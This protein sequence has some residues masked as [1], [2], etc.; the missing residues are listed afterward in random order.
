MEVAGQVPSLV[1]TSDKGKR[2]LQPYRPQRS[3]V[4]SVLDALKAVA[5][6]ASA[7]DPPCWL[8]DGNFPDPANVIAFANGLLDVEAYLAGSVDLLDHTPNWFSCNCLPHGFDQD[9]VCPRWLEFLDQ[10]FDGDASGSPASS[11]GWA[12]TSSPTIG[13]K[14]WRC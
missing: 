9:A 6:H 14:N 7:V 11:S 4:T 10:V 1:Q 12:T 2:V 8:E 3:F 13:S 5:N